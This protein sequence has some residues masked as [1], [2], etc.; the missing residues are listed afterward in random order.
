VELA[1]LTNS[2]NAQAAMGQLIVDV[3]SESADLV[4]KQAHQA[5]K[6]TIQSA[7][8]SISLEGLGENVDLYA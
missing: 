8:P 2:L 7:A 4:E 5:V 6:M 3:L 1:A